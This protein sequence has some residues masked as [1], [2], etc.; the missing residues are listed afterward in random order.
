MEIDGFNEM[1]MEPGGTEAEDQC[2][3][4]ERKTQRTLRCLNETSSKSDGDCR[5]ECA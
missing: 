2:S 1:T 3:E 5:K 4:L